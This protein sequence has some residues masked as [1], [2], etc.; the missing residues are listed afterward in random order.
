MKDEI[1]KASKE[2][3]D[4]ACDLADLTGRLKGNLPEK[5]ENLDAIANF[6][7]LAESA[8]AIQKWLLVVADRQI[9]LDS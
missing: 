8:V 7:L 3:L 4:L 9:R 1:D 6:G 5:L 2:A